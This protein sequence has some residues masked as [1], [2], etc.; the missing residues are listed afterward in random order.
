MEDGRALGQR[1]QRQL[2]LSSKDTFRHPALG[3]QPVDVLIV[4][5]NRDG[6]HDAAVEGDSHGVCVC[7]TSGENPVVIAAPA[8]EPRTT[9][10]EGQPGDQEYVYLMQCHRLTL[11]DRLLHSE[12]V[13][14]GRDIAVSERE[15]SVLLDAGQHPSPSWQSLEQR[16]DVDL[17]G[18][19]QVRGHG[20]GES[21]RHPYEDARYDEKPDTRFHGLMTARSR[22]YLG[23]VHVPR[24]K[25]E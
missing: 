24:V 15:A 7:S 20:P 9:G 25:V 4:V 22:S 23:F 14:L 10:I 3:G 1:D 18:E 16:S 19:R 6:V 17:V 5:V 8:T 12:P 21:W 13:D 2:E 11:I